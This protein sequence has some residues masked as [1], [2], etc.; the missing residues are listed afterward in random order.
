MNLENLLHPAG[1]VATACAVTCLLRAFPFLLF[2]GGRKTPPCVEAF[3]RVISPLVIAGLLVYSS[4]GLECRLIAPWAAGVL[5]VG[6][7]L[8]IRNALLS[9]LGGT[10]LY[11]TLLHFGV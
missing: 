4:C 3:G 5:T 7:Q 10:A 9:I 11:M 8:A 6:L 1:V 2:G